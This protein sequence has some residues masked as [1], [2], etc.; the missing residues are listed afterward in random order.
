VETEKE[1]VAELRAVQVAWGDEWVPYVK[2]RV[3]GYQG[4]EV[5]TRIFG[6]RRVIRGDGRPTVDGGAIGWC[7][8]RGC[9]IGGVGGDTEPKEGVAEQEVE[10]RGRRKRGS[11]IE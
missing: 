11:L 1:V 6:C 2:I 10:E 4:E 3:G 9:T 8:G 5:S 7:L